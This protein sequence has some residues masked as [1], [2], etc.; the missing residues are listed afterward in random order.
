[1]RLILEIILPDGVN[2]SA[3]DDVNL[4]VGVSAFSMKKPV[5]K[6]E[7]VEGNYVVSSMLPGVGDSIASS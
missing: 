1:M 3:D 5:F 2:S 4:W 6:D 7:E